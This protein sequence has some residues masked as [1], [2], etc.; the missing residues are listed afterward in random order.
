VT[1]LA[2]RTGAATARWKDEIM[3]RNN[4]FE[5]AAV[6]LAVS[7]VPFIEKHYRVLPGKD[8]RAIAGLSM[9]GGRAVQATNNNPDAFGWKA[10]ENVGLPKSYHTAPGAHFWF[11]WRQFLSDFAT[12][13]F[14]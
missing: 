11:I 10:A 4:R 7:L 3:L 8:N 13:L 12:I 5:A 14:R 2:E 6:V 9:G 1:T